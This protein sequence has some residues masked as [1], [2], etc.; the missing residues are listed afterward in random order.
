MEEDYSLISEWYYTLVR[1]FK[2]LENFFVRD[3]FIRQ[4]KLSGFAAL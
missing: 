2:I 4:A 1:V 3:C